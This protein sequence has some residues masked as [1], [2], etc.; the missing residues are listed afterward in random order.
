MA[1]QTNYDSSQATGASN[2]M[3]AD[4]KTQAD[5]TMKTTQ[6]MTMLGITV[7]AFNTQLGVLKDVH[8]KSHD[9]TKD[10]FTKVG[11]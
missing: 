2:N 5:A 1:V 11:R 4:A 9:V 8:T 7:N 6:E 10:V 3:A